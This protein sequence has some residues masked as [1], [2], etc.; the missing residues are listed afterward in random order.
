MSQFEILNN[1]IIKC[2]RVMHPISYDV[3]SRPWDCSSAS[4]CIGFRT[5]FLSQFLIAQSSP[6]EE[7]QANREVHLCRSMRPQYKMGYMYSYT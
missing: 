3:T 4:A 2:C 7:R 6:C 5:P 1:Q